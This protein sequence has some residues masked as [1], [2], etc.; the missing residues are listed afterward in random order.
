VGVSWEMI[1]SSALSLIAGH[2]VPAMFVSMGALGIGSTMGL[3][4]GSSLLSDAVDTDVRVQVQGT[5]DLL[6]A[7]SGGAAGLTA[8]VILSSV[9][10]GPLGVVAALLAIPILVD[11]RRES[12][13]RVRAA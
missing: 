13:R 11:L 12:A 4:A 8:G 3:I 2:D 7:L 6:T 1:G 9:G 5:A 10:F